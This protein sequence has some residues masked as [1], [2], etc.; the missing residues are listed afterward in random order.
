MSAPPPPP[1]PSF[2][3]GPPAAGSDTGVN[4]LLQSIRNGKQLKKTVTI[5][6]SAPCIAGRV[7][8]GNVNGNNNSNNNTNNNNNSLTSPTSLTKNT[9]NN[10]GGSP[11]NLG[12][13]FAGGMPKLKPT[14]LRGTIVDKDNSPSPPSTGNLSYSHTIKRG[15]PPVPPPA[16]QKPQMS[17]TN[18]INTNDTLK[19]FGKPVIAR[20]PPGQSSSTATPTPATP[21]PT[22]TT[23]A[24]P[25]QATLSTPPSKPYP[26]PKKLDL[27]RAGSVSRAQSMRL[28]RSPP[29][30]APSPSSLH[31]SQDFLNE[32]QHRLTNRILKPPVVRP[33]SPPTSRS[34]TRTAPPPPTRVAVPTMPPPPPPPPHRTSTGHQRHAPPPPTRNLSLV[35]DQTNN[36]TSYITNDFEQRFV[37]LFHSISTFPNP[38]QFRGVPKLYN[39]K[40]AAKQ[41]APAPPPPPSQSSTSSIQLNASSGV[42][43]WQHNAASSAC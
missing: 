37:K 32:T 1:P 7:K 4:L 2:N 12:G 10:N 18:D 5:D 27:I 33:P 38:E 25:L 41:Q 9:S 28:P 36:Q 6:K 35:N 14:G 42:K 43:Q 15:P 19:G 13:L 20:K 40:N 11:I 39:S 8:N 30:L 29:V 24:S 34:S 16:T 31:Q 23:T 21:T 26:P 3:I 22:I 17:N